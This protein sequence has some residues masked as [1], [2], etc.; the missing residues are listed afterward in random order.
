M[1]GQ[2]ALHWALAGGAIAII[3][4]ALLYL[5]G[6]RL[7]ISTGFESVCS[8]V[9]DAPYFLRDALHGK[10]RWRLTFLAG[11]LAGGVLSAVL[12]GGWEPTW[13][14]GMFDATFGSDKGLKVGWMFAGGLFIGFGT[15]LAGGC[16]SGHGIFGNANFE[17]ASLKSTASFMIAGIVTTNVVYRLIGGV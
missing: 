1:H 14:L 12:A 17:K 11:L 16:T 9:S 13:N 7:G 8:I 15:R 10:G 6:R 5:T 3:T 4:I 2:E